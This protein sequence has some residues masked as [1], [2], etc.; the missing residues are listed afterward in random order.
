MLDKPA[1]YTYW[2]GGGHWVADWHLAAALPGSGPEVSVRWNAYLKAYVMIYVPPFGRT[3]EARF[4]PAPEGPWSEPRKLAD[5][6]PAS[7]SVAMFYGAKQHAEL[8]VEGGR[9]IFVTYNTNVA[10]ELITSRSDLYWPRLVRVTFEK[11]GPAPSP[12]PGH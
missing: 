3:I 6:Q 4:A 5:C 9:R 12:T 7:D 11:A 2:A 1:A 10:P 8:D